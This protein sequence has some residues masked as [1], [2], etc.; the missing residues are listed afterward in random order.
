[1]DVVTK[2]SV[3]ELVKK[4]F[5]HVLYKMGCAHACLFDKWD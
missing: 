5:I 4:H 3:H 2:L 1:M